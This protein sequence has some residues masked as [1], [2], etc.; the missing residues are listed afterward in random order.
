MFRAMIESA[1]ANELFEQELL[2]RL[3]EFYKLIDYCNGQFKEISITY[4]M[5]VPVI[6]KYAH[7]TS[8]KYNVK[9]SVSLQI[10][11]RDEKNKIQAELENKMRVFRDNQMSILRKM[12]YK[13]SEERNK[14]LHL[15]ASKP[16]Q[17]EKKSVS[18]S[19]HK[20]EKEMN[21]KRMKMV[22]SNNADYDRELLK[23]KKEYETKYN[24]VL[25][26]SVS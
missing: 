22:E 12:S 17:E 19:L 13:T 14:M 16:T 2:G 23:L 3:E 26:V 1:N 8:T 11:R 6:D 18:D 24:I 15:M 9:G 25:S 5:V 4:G 20:Y 21:E 10:V 7:V